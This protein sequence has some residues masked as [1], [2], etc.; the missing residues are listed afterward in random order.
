VELDGHDHGN[1]LLCLAR[2]P[3]PVQVT[4]NGYIDTTGM[5]AIDWR[6]TDESHDQ[7]GAT[8][9]FHTERLYRLPGGCW[10]YTADDDPPAAREPPLLRNGGG[11]RFGCLNKLLKVSPRAAR[12]WARVLDAVPGSR[13]VL[14]TAGPAATHADV[15]RGLAAAGL[16]VDRVMLLERAA[17]RRE[18][19]QRFSDIDISL[20]P[21]PFNGITT[22]CD[23]LWMGV[24]V[25]SLAGDSF[26][27]RSG[28]S[29]LTGAGVPH[30]VA[31][32]EAEYV[33]L[34]T[35]LASDPARLATT[36]AELRG[37][38]AASPLCDGPAFARPLEAAYR[39]MW[40]EWC[41]SPARP[42]CLSRRLTGRVGRYC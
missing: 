9:E 32:Y 3:A 16:P 33:R 1:R 17:D 7:P 41:E 35:S 40:H 37:R 4:C 12:A 38:M 19:L 6:I 39:S 8:D 22:T 5:A 27:S 31:R 2:R 10:C 36:R 42:P 20:D 11:V 14:V 18:Y 34:A 21:F 28:L 29:L 26:V 15:R 23:S 24:P 25:V 30:L 13:L